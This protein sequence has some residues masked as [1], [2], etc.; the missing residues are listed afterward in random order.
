MPSGDDRCTPA[1]VGTA[2]LE[3]GDLLITSRALRTCPV[4]GAAN[5][6]CGR[7]TN[8]VPVDERVSGPA[9]RRP[10]VRIPLGRGVSVQVREEEA[11]R[12]GLL[13]E[14]KA[15]QPPENKIR[16]PRRNKVQKE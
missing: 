16:R 3:R 1:P 11:R 9:A 2:M 12:L 4:C 7:P 6:T 13:P 8:V 5:C 15:K 14:E 10:L